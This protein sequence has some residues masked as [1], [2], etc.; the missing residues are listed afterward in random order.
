MKRLILIDGNSIM[1]R[2]YYA[3]AY[4]GAVLMQ[5]SKGEYTNA[6]F[7]FIN[8][9][10][11]IVTSDDDNVLVAFDTSAPTFRHESYTEYKAGRKEV[12]SELAE[13]IPRIH[14]YIELLGIKAYFKEGYEAD[15]LIGIYAKEASAENIKVDIYS[16]DRDLLQL[17]DENI[18]VNLLKKGMQD[19]ASYT[20]KT[21]FDEF[22]LTHEQ[23][24]DLKALMGDSSDNIPGVPGIGP[25]TATNLLKEYT[26]LENV[27]E[28]INNIKG[29]VQ[30][31][32]LNHKDLALMS[33]QLVTIMTKGELDYK[34]DDLKRDL[35]D[36]NELI[37]FLQ[38]YEL[39]SFVKQLDRPKAETKELVF[40]VVNTE[41]KLRKVLKN[42]LAIHFEFSDSNYHLADIWGIGLYDGKKG[43][44]VDPKLLS[45]NVFVEY[46][47]DNNISKMTYDYKA[48]K[49][50]LLWKEI[51]F[52]NCS[53]DL[54]LAAYLID[55]HFGKEEF[56]YI[57]SNFDFEQ[58]EY[59][60]LIYGK[61]V[62]K[63]LPEDETLY[64]H[65][66]VSK[67]KAIFELKDELIN[68]LKKEE[69]L[70]LLT[71]VELPLSSVLAKMEYNGILVSKEELEVQKESLEKRIDALT[72][73]I[74]MLAGREFNV[75][76]PK[77]L[78]EVLFEDLALPFG[79]K[80][81]TGY[82]TNA[83]V[84]NKLK[85]IHP[86]IDKILD[87]RELNKL[88]TTYIVGL[89]N[90]IFPDGKIHT[91]YKQALTTTGRLSSVE[92]NLQ[93][94]P[95]RTEEG[96]QIR[97]VFIASDDTLLLGSDY[98]QIELRVLADMADVKA[99]QQAFND[100]RDIHSETAKAVFEISNDVTSE[101]RRAAK[102]VNFGII[103]GI[104]A[105]SLSEDL[106]I[107]P[108][109]AQNFI[110]K[111]LEVYPEI[112]KY[113]EDIVSFAV[114]NGYVETMI[115]RRR[116]IPEL[117]SSVFMQKEFGKRTALNA[118]IQGTAADILKIAMID[119]DKY[120]VNNNKKSKLLL[121]VH[122][123]LILEVYQDEL[124]EMEEIVPKIMRD[125]YKLKVELK[126]SCEVGKT[127]FEI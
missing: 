59:D 66:I 10:S 115:K 67:A 102:A 71:E 27:Y 101:Q 41:D 92:P 72:K 69:Q 84:L 22:E 82:S 113:M 111:Y 37:S 32:L 20:P 28:N 118:P 25:K 51:E 24:I 68:R 80:N 88:Y 6:L 5:T 107:T 17:V 13:Q 98:S 73:E 114:N 123:E 90:V 14:K 48:S 94:I 109:E 106:N 95:T 34:I 99:L 23:M 83:D 112:K 122:D 57:V 56:K 100:S 126:A 103:Y 96:R 110:D 86:I 47:E 9:F 75:A 38:N 1:F 15:D 2:A 105:W 58:V 39:H 35:Y 76:S 125:A 63:G 45:S 79:K 40:E 70:H 87:F 3:T 50:S 49:V 42:N 81:K 117:K 77:Q 52:N 8:L 54:L 60:E 46:L 29:K 21:L 26:T 30:E 61:G 36:Q 78:G 93:N 97:K 108:K 62:K 31:N 43:Y 85:H 12:P 91:I 18:T 53:F 11:K 124:K 65:H 44:F 89:L 119:L 64:Q 7:A 33:K 55:S 74:I 127:W 121:Q 4:P 116:Y 19:V 120:L 16:S 104:G